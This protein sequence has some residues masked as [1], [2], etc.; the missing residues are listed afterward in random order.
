MSSL[1]QGHELTRYEVLL[2]ALGMHKAGIELVPVDGQDF[3]VGGGAIGFMK[4]GW[5]VCA[6]KKE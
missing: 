3:V 5:M 1:L 4:K 2:F 6:V